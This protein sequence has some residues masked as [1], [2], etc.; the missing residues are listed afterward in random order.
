MTLDKLEVGKD[1]VIE[2]VGGKGALRRHFLDMGL[3]PGTE[4]TMMKKAPMGD[5]IELRL[6]SY[7]LTLRLADAAQIEISGIH[8]TDTVRSRQAHLKD[9]PHPQVG[10]MGIYHVRKK[11]NEL[12]EGEPLTF[13]LIGNQNCGKTT[14]FNQLTGANQH[15]GNFPGVTVDR[16]DGQ[17]K[18]HPEATVTDLP[19]IYSLSPY[20]NEEIVTRDFLIQNKPRGIIN[21]V[22][23]TNIERNLY[24]TMQ[25]IEMDIPMVLA[26][27][28]MDEVRE[29]GG[30]IQVNRLEEALGIPVIPI[31]AAKNE[32]IGELIEHAI[33]VARYDE[34]P[35]RL[36]FCDA[37]GEN[38][39][40][41]IHRCIHAVVHLIEDH[42]KK[43]EIPARFAATKLV[44]GDKLI[45][46]QLG[47]DR[48]EEETLEHMIHEMEEECAKDREAAL[49][50]MRFKF[51]EKVCTQTVV[52]PTESKAHARSVKADKILT[53]KYTALP[54][55]AA[56]MGLI[57]WL[58]FGV[59]G[60]GLSDWLSVGIDIV[61]DFADR[62]LTAYG[63]NPVVHSLIIDGIFAGVGS[64]LSFLPIIVVLFFFLSI[65]EDS[66]YMARIA[67]VMDK[68]LRKIGLSGRSFV[69]MIIGFGC[70]VPAIMA[71][72][73]LS[74]ER[75]RKM[76]ILL[77]PFMS[78]SAK[79]PI[80]ALFTYAFFPKYRA[81]VMV[82]LYFTGI[83]VGVLFSLLLKNTAFQGEPVP[84]VMELPNYRLPSLKSVGMLIWDKA[85][86]FIT[87]AFTIIFMASIV[88]WFLQTFDVRLNVVVDSKDSLL[89]LIGGFAAPV[90]VPLGFGDWRISTALIT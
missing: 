42:A 24:L 43:A 3:T 55:F 51:I 45:L 46:Q 26:L 21:I 69:P 29:N 20:T 49:A 90:F 77:T 9:I 58:T 80:Y 59:I 5:P 4:V 34:W 84:F 39:Q 31:S 81:L 25:L 33:H 36:D 86:D 76:T 88:I 16:K 18:N 6:R 85:K 11:G 68:L 28:M 70:S 47:L 12:R 19:G 57:F 8:D 66:G 38:G 22:D 44:E 60:A 87:K 74:S 73:T 7:E 82:G 75:D 35:G 27:N 17:I 67:F 83:I 15:V 2:S 10:E 13:G 89:A 52:K 37:N 79:L 30:T 40:A 54:A 71:T 65:L 56:I 62:A 41:A 23:A 50:D 64:V 32:G 61:T 72:R 1:A 48:N 53:G 14:L 78:C 63:L